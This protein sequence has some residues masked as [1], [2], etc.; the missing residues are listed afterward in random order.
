MSAL[1]ANEDVMIN[2]LQVHFLS[3]LA[4]WTAAIVIIA[5]ASVA[6]AQQSFKTPEDAVD[7]SCARYKGKLA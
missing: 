3:K 1:D 7:S 6:S 5:L 2:A 4:S